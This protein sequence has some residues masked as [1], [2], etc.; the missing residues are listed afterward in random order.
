MCKSYTTKILQRYSPT[1]DVPWSV[2]I[3]MMVIKH[4]ITYVFQV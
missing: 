3:I 1:P 4:K 2:D